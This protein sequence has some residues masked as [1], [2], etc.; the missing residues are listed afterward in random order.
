MHTIYQNVVS[1]Q[2]ACVYLSSL[3]T[4]VVEC[5]PA[6]SVAA[7]PMQAQ[8]GSTLRQTFT[9]GGGTSQVVVYSLT[10]LS[11]SAA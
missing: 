9:H 6:C 4:H 3:Q 7:V 11:Y 1:K 8:T 10:Q 5:S 2:H